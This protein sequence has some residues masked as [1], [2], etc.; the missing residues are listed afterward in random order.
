MSGEKFDDFASATGVAKIV[1]TTSGDLLDIPTN[2]CLDLIVTEH[3][4][5]KLPDIALP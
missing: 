2:I 4:K 1:K 5:V 3:S